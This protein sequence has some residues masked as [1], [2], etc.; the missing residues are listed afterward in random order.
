MQPPVKSALELFNLEIMPP[1]SPNLYRRAKVVLS[2][3]YIT[4]NTY[5]TLFKAK[6]I[7]CKAY[8]KNLLPHL[9]FIL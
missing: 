3:G 8:D 6:N 2:T 1:P 7:S 9:P 4:L 5:L